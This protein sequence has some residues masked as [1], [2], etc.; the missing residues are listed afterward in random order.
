MITERY[1]DFYREE[2]IWRPW[3]VIFQADIFGST[4]VLQQKSCATALIP[5]RSF[6]GTY[7]YAR[8]MET[9]NLMSA[10]S[11]KRTARDG[12]V[13]LVAK[14]MGPVEADTLIENGAGVDD[15]D[16]DP[17]SLNEVPRQRKGSKA[18]P[19]GNV[20]Q[21]HIDFCFSA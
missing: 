7:G 16:A 9:S 19:N 20:G 1:F 2:K 5:L 3:F 4:G 12:Q 11:V 14:S 18:A 10:L 6:R 17:L 13:P 15:F 8:L 21:S